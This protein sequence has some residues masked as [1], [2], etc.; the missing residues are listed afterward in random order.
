MSSVPR[1]VA[2]H[3]ERLWP[4]PLGWLLVV[5]FGVFAFIAV[6]PVSPLAAAL[7]GVGAVVV[8]GAIAVRTATRVVVVDGEL[9]A[10]DAHIPV[11]LLGPGEALDR[12]SLRAALGPGSD[13]RTFRCV[14]AWIPGAVL[15]E[16]VDPADPTPAWL[17]STRRPA[18]LVA[19]L[20][21]GRAGA[22]A[23]HSEQIG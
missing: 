18:G 7:T 20:S 4:G 14:R 13:A 21:S 11:A 9:R 1:P 2:L 5:G 17:V 15:V 16:V 6:F 22:Q 23:A 12:A 3:D 10:G 19:A 8:G